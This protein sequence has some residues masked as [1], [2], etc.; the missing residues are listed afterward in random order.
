MIFNKKKVETCLDDLIFCRLPS[1]TDNLFLGY[2]TDT[3][4][5]YE[6]FLLIVLEILSEL[7]KDCVVLTHIYP[8]NITLGKRH[9]YRKVELSPGAFDFIKQSVFQ[10]AHQVSDSS[11][12]VIVQTKEIDT[13]LLRTFYLWP[14]HTDFENDIYV[15]PQEPL[16]TDFSY[17]KLAA[18]LKSSSPRFIFSYNEFHVGLNIQIIESNYWTDQVVSVVENICVKYGLNPDTT[19]LAKES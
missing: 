17:P 10:K 19:F 13:E 18:E 8:Q 12:S 15:F 16:W 11:G 6:K 7:S 1:S 3:K 2:H 9:G 5:L 14:Q 4:G